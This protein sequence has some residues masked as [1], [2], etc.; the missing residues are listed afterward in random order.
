[1]Q[2]IIIPPFLEEHKL[3]MFIF[4]DNDDEYT[5]FADNK[6]DAEKHLLEYL[7]DIDCPNS[8]EASSLEDLDIYYSVDYEV[9]EG[10]VLLR[11]LR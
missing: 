11:S 10:E 8:E 4:N 9:I 6:R 2:K 3:K 5:V 1:M 7:G